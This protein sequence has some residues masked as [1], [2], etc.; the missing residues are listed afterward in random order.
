LSHV[1]LPTCYDWFSDW[2][3]PFWQQHH[4]KHAAESVESLPTCLDNHCG[5]RAKS[6]V[7]PNMATETQEVQYWMGLDA[8]VF[9]KVGNNKKNSNQ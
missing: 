7:R 6:I 3:Y 9:D 1:D 4:P 5:S 8:L 2:S